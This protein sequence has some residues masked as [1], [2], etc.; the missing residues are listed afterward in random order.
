[1]AKMKNENICPRCIGCVYEDIAQPPY[2]CPDCE[3][4]YNESH[5]SHVVPE[6]QIM[7]DV[8]KVLANMIV[9]AGCK[10]CHSYAGVRCR[11]CTWNDAMD[12]VEDAIGDGR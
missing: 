7:V 3:R 1:M 9:A 10:E 12:I 5:F 8:R 4:M 6:E 2:I 11:A